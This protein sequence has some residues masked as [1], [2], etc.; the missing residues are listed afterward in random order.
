MTL[1]KI[2]HPSPVGPL[3]LFASAQGLVAIEFE[4]GHR[5]GRADARDDPDHPVLG[6]CR[7]QLDAYFAG[8]LRVFEVP[9]A[10]AG[11]DFQRA[12][13]RVLQE[14]PFG[15]TESYGWVA[16]QIGNPKAVRA[17]GLANG[18]NPLPIVVP[19]HRVI[20]QDGT[21]TGYGGGLGRKQ[22]LLALEGITL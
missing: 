21:L 19:C 15:R 16:R 4:H 14:I 13:W 18:R 17:V 12:V 2:Q 11:T 5:A 3:T 7:A 9:L 6:Q 22:T 1:S 20:G 10:A 8:K